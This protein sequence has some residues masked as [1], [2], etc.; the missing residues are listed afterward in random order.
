M[1]W[2]LSLQFSIAVGLI[3]ITAASNTTIPIFEN[4]PLQE[5]SPVSPGDQFRPYE[6]RQ[7][8]VSQDDLENE[9]K[10]GNPAQLPE[11][12]EFELFSI[13]KLGDVLLLSGRIANGDANR[14]TAFLDDL[15]KPPDHIAFHSPG[16]RL[17]E[18]LEIGREIRNREH[19]TLL[20]PNSICLSSCPYSF[21]GG[22]TRTVS[23][24]AIVGLHQHYF[25]QPKYLPVVFAVE[26]I[27]NGQAETM[28]HLKSM[29]VDPAISILAMKTAPNDIYILLPSEL[30]EY[31]LA[32]SLLERP[33]S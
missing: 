28:E 27:Q 8:R 22:I 16:G 7:F 10:L 21:A 14:F 29:G 18:A 24:K 13:P 31:L 6:V 26:A 12:I 25:E 19:N 3:L 11:N 4:R 23:D 32:T 30:E 9:I 1:K 5:Y 20:T 2:M 17:R 33:G 15:V